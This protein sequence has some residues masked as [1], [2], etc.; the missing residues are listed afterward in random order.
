[1]QSKD[2]IPC[3]YGSACQQ[4]LL[5]SHT[6][7]FSHPEWPCGVCTFLNP[8]EKKVCMMC[9]SRSVTTNLQD[10]LPLN[11]DWRVSAPLTDNRPSWTFHDLPPCPNGMYCKI[12]TDQ[13]TRQFSHLSSGKNDFKIR[14]KKVA[15]AK[16][17]RR[18]EPRKGIELFIRS[19]VHHPNS[20][21][22]QKSHASSSH[23][24]D[25]W[26][27]AS[28]LSKSI[29]STDSPDNPEDSKGMTKFDAD[30]RDTKDAN[31]EKVELI[32][33]LKNNTNKNSNCSEEILASVGA[34]NAALDGTGGE[35]EM[36]AVTGISEASAVLAASNSRNE[37]S[38]QSTRAV[39]DTLPEAKTNDDLGSLLSAVEKGQVDEFHRCFVPISASSGSSSRFLHFTDDKGNRPLT[40]ACAL[41][42][43]SIVKSLVEHAAD[44]NIANHDGI[45][46]MLAAALGGHDQVVS[47]GRFRFAILTYKSLFP[48]DICCD[49]VLKNMVVFL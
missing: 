2:T 12:D 20:S 31:E 10:T 49:S 42:H 7:R 39:V 38:S 24:G 37:E 46:P 4:L 48:V 22:C 15:F 40:T 9:G 6:R 41:G 33:D 8:P 32:S 25:S 18:S 43:L 19:L 45:T 21:E 5:T 16:Q 28:S 3:K 14:G 23:S 27:D 34:T 36:S 35:S 29:P 1:M 26:I 30:H 44:I 11:A 17:N 47:L 13:H